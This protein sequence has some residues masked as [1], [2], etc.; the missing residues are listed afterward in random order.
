MARWVLRPP[1]PT[2]IS[3]ATFRS[4]CTA[5]PPASLQLLKARE[6]PISAAAGMVVRDEYSDERTGAR[7]CQG[8]HADDPGQDSDDDREE[9][10][11]VDKV[12]DRPDALQERLWCLTRCS[13]RRTEGQRDHDRGE[14]PPEQ[15]EQAVTHRPAVPLA[16]SQRGGDD[17]VVLG[18]DHHRTDDEDFRIG[19]DAHGTDQPGDG[20][21]DKEARGIDRILTDSGFHHFPHGSN[22]TGIRTDFPALPGGVSQGGVHLFHGNRIIVIKTEISQHPE[23]RVCRVVLH[24]EKDG[25]AVRALCGSLEHDQILYAGKRC[26]LAEQP[27]GDARRAHHADVQHHEPTR[28]DSSRIMIS[29]LSAQVGVANRLVPPAPPRCHSRARSLPPERRRQPG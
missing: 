27:P 20:Q 5:E 25:V 6:T 24:V 8:H 28:A 10:R 26:K 7:L 13:Y 17:R 16:D 1:A 12:R 19:Q 18:A 3:R 2:T 14:E 23:H 11:G 29:P 21:Q 15:G 22:L 4:N 9:I